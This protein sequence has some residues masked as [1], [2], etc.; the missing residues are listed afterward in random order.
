VT[1]QFATRGTGSG[2]AYINRTHTNTDTSEF[3]RTAS[4]ITLME[5]LA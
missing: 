3:Q 4:E 1:Y 5:V 2:T